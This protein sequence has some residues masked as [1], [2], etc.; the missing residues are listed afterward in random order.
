MTLHKPSTAIGVALAILAAAAFLKFADQSGLI[1]GDA[2]S[3]AVMAATGLVLAAIGNSVPKQLKRARSSLAAERR[4]Q[5]AL[6]RVGW[7]VT[8]AG[9][10]VGALWVLAPEAWAQPLSLMILG[11]AFLVVVQAI[12]ACRIRSLDASDAPAGG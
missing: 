11:A 9:V 3:R 6:R 2:G 1:D 10:A 8:L 5:A 12:L 4:V 7:A